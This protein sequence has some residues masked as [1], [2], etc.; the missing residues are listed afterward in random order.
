MFIVTTEDGEISIGDQGSRW[1]QV[2]QK[3]ETGHPFRG[4]ANQEIKDDNARMEKNLDCCLE[5]PRG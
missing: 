5:P 4:P 2:P 3:R 1:G